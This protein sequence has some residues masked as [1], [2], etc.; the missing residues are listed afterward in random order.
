MV[1]VKFLDFE[2][3]VDP[4]GDKWR[5]KRKSTTKNGLVF[6]PKNV[7]GLQTKMAKYF[8]AVEQIKLKYLN[9]SS[10]VS[11]FIISV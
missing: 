2:I 1:I 5:L 3:T 4:S 6:R 9:Y 10:S 8:H 11:R 7:L